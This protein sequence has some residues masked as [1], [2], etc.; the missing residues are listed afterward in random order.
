MKKRNY[1]KAV[2][3]AV[4]EN[5]ALARLMTAGFLMPVGVTA[6]QLADIKTLV[7]EAV[8]NAVV[9]AYRDREAGEVKMEMSL[10]EKGILTVTVRDF[11]CGIGDVEQAM[12]PFFTTDREGERSGMGL[13]IIQAFSD[14]FKLRSDARGTKL[15]MKKKIL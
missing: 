8:T 2:F 15:V 13:P 12:E 1:L 11:G 5:E 9:H 3:P 10:N 14:S 7:S 4:S 6:Q